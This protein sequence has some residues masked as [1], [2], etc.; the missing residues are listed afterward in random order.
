[1]VT[2]SHSSAVAEMDLAQPVDSNRA[3]N[4]RGEYGG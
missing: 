4:F 3:V 1:M 2:R